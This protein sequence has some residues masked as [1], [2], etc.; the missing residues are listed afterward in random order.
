M[1][2]WGPKSFSSIPARVLVNCACLQGIEILQEVSICSLSQVCLLLQRLDLVCNLLRTFL[3]QC[4][5]LQLPQSLH[6]L[7]LQ[8]FGALPPEIYMGSRSFKDLTS[9]LLE[10]KRFAFASED[11]N[12]TWNLR[13]RLL[14]RSY[15]LKIQKV[16]WD[17]KL[18]WTD[19]NKL[20]AFL[21]VP[22]QLIWH[23]CRLPIFCFCTM[24]LTLTF[25]NAPRQCHPLL[26]E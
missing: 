1:Y 26:L 11:A 7:V 19:L 2:D 21:N 4:S 24:E 17:S 18:N 22:L 9:A 25:F 13:I 15:A 14:C 12:A 6:F 20:A 5:F 8:M 3:C 10:L 23:F 16:S